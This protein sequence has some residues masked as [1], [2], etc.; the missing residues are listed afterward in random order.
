MNIA[1]INLIVYIYYLMLYPLISCQLFFIPLIKK[2]ENTQK[3][4]FSDIYL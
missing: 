2:I 3:V 4:L 1:N